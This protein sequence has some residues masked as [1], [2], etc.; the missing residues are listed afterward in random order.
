M[1][2]SILLSVL[3]FL[4]L[5]I[6][7]R[8]QQDS[9]KTAL[10]IKYKNNNI[11]SAINEE[12]DKKMK[13]TNTYPDSIILPP[14]HFVD[15]FLKLGKREVP[16]ESFSI[17]ID[18]KTEIPDGYA[19]YIAPLNGEINHMPFYGGIQTQSNGIS[20]K[21]GVVRNIGRGGIFSRWM[22][23]SEKALKTKGYY[24]SSD[25]EGDFISVRNKVKWDKGLYR[26][27]IYKSS[28][29]PGKPLPNPLSSQSIIFSWGEYEHS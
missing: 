15:T 12:T 5:I 20:I 2:L 13:T 7:I 21:N 11:G 25:A 26:I 9:T 14:L 23:R 28:Y 17:D 29:V 16:F 27:K 22:E 19:F 24:F 4:L 1:K 6:P 8:A 18:V 10:K 3:F